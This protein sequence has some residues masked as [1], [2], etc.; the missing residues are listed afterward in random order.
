M[1]VAYRPIHDISL[2]KTQL[3][4]MQCRYQYLQSSMVQ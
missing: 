4:S 1:A 2:Q 3:D